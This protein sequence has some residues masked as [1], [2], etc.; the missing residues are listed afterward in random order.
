VNRRS[1][2]QNPLVFRFNLAEADPFDFVILV[3][4]GLDRIKLRLSNVPQPNIGPWDRTDQ[5]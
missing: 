4:S 2:D 5:V 1:V 3:D